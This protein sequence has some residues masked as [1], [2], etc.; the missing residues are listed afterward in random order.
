[1][2]KMSNLTIENDDLRNGGKGAQIELV[3]FV[4]ANLFRLAF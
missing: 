3:F 1:M 2:M 4:R